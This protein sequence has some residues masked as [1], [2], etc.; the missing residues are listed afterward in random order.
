MS[1]VH[2]KEIVESLKLAV[3]DI[4]TSSSICTIDASCLNNYIELFL[5]KILIYA[6][7]CCSPP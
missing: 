5:S 7:M 4:T 6:K 1:L 2:V 3:E